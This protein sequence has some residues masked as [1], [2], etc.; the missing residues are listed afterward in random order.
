MEEKQKS[1]LQNDLVT[2]VGDEAEGFFLELV[3]PLSS[4]V[5]TIG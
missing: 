3:E 1:S 4:K 2:L 5:Y